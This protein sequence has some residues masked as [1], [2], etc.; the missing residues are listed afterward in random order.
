MKLLKIISFIVTLQ[1]TQAHAEGVVVLDGESGREIVQST[2]SANVNTDDHVVVT[3][4]SAGVAPIIAPTTATVVLPEEET[5]SAVT[6]TTTNGNDGKLILNDKP[7]L[8]TEKEQASLQKAEAKTE[9]KVEPKASAEV[10]TEKVV[11]DDEAIATKIAEE[12]KEPAKEIFG[13]EKKLIDSDNSEDI[14]LRVMMSKT[15]VQVY[16]GYLDS[17]WNTVSNRL[18]NGSDM[19]GLRVSKEFLDGWESGLALE[20]LSERKNKSA[21]ESLRVFHS[22]IFVDYTHS[23]TDNRRFGVI[24][25]GALSYGDYRVKRVIAEAG[26]NITYENLGDGSLVGL[27]PSLGLRYRASKFFHLDGVVERPVFFGSVQKNIGGL[28][29][30]ARFSLL[31]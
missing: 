10:S 25:G 22:K 1:F 29:Y 12:P 13:K 14:F 4:E 30:L 9:A 16:F 5:S 27:T 6:N 24:F 28:G 18:K 19:T 31:W 20:F 23:L 17:G 26:R 7:Q 11:A 8:G 2:E 21:L 3:E 15:W